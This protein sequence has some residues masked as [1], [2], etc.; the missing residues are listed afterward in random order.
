[1]GFG[2]T[3]HWLTVSLKGRLSKED[4]LSPHL[5]CVYVCVCVQEEF[6]RFTGYW[7]Q[8]EEGFDG[9]IYRILFEEVSSVCRATASHLTYSVHARLFACV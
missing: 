5:L 8:P 9:R 7:W 2:N 3:L 4:C 6:D 1:M